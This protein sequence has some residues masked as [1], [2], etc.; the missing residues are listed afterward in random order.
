MG[1]ELI[2]KKQAGSIIMMFIFGSSLV[3][4]ISTKTEQDS[5]LVLLMTAV[6]V[7]PLLLVYARIVKL[8]P[9]LDIF[10]ILEKLL[11]RVAGKLVVALMCWYALHLA[12]MV[13]RNFSEFI[14]VSTMPE[15]PQ[16][17]IMIGMMLVTAYIAKSG[18]ESLGRWS[19]ATVCVVLFAVLLTV[20]LSVNKLE[21][22]HIQPVLNHSLG[23]MASASFALFSYPFAE[24]VLML[25]VANAIKTQDS[26]YKL[27]LGATMLGAFVLLIVLLRNIVLLGA[28]MASAEYFP[29]Y[30]AAR[31]IDVGDFLSR[32][33]ITIGM[34]FILAGI[35]KIS[36]CL[37]AATKGAARLF[38]VSDYRRLVMP[39]GLV[40]I[41]L[42][43]IAYK[44]TM[45]MFAFLPVYQYYAMPFQIF[46]PLAV[47]ILAEVKNKKQKKQPE[48]ASD[49]M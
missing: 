17:P 3:M 24:T 46:I 29:S 8:N 13:L 43:V 22:S 19:L 12:A 1:K 36:V 2:S 23:D 39:V 16:L 27:Y 26:P 6:C 28:P 15:T 48:I 5:W 10:E 34:N 40:T 45:E 33:E 30:A 41:A 18:I 32:I 42:S 20:L 38:G 44:S 49:V 47:W 4:G 25:G 9:G 21:L 31:I 7:I 14:Q 37:I 35:V 11:G